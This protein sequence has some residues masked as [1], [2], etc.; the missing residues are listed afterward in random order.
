[1]KLVILFGSRARG[2]FTETSDYD[3]L[4]VGDEVP[5]DPRMIPE[6]VY[7]RATKMFPGEV[8]PVFVNS[9][10]FLKKLREGSPFFL[11]IMEEGKVLLKDDNFW[12]KA[13]GVYKEVRSS[14]ERKGKT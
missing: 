3:A 13:L 2:D 1:M 6:D 7:V 10:V 12:E 14:F 8:D 11:Q 4:L 5:R 9:E